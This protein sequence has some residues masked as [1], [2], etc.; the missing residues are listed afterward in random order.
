ML[1][2]PT[3]AFFKLWQE[4]RERERERE[5]ERERK[6]VGVR[7]CNLNVSLPKDVA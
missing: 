1:E 5:I 3:L 4:E 7:H 2:F 6:E